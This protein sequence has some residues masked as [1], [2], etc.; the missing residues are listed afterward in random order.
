MEDSRINLNDAITGV[1]QEAKELSDRLRESQ[2]ESAR[3]E[4]A[5]ADRVRSL[6][7]PNMSIA[8]EFDDFMLV[9]AA[10]CGTPHA[11]ITVL[12]ESFTYVKA[13]H[14]FD[15]QM[16]IPRSESICDVCVT[17]SSTLVIEDPLSDPLVNWKKPVV[18]DNLKFYAGSPLMSE[19]GY[20]LGVICVFDYVE[21]HKPTPKQIEILEAI[22]RMITNKLIV[23]IKN[24][25]VFNLPVV[26]TLPL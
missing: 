5:R 17:K 13:L 11:A 12:D 2:E 26:F 24:P 9:A 22:S 1:I 21:Y 23:M 19:D 25:T 15:Y 18:D 8:K 14:G 10:A 16:V 3:R 20:S 7:L 6:N 4:K